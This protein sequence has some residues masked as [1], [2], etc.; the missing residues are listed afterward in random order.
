MSQDTSSRIQVT[1]KWSKQTYQLTLDKSESAIA[2]KQNIQALT[3]VPIH[4]QKLLASKKGA[5]K[6]PLKDDYPMDSIQPQTQTTTS[7]STIPL[8]IVTLI[9]SADVLSEGPKIKTR[10]EEDLTM[11]EIRAAE[12]VTIQQAM[13][14]SHGMIPAFQKLPHERNDNKAE[15]YQYNHMV[16]G[17]P[18]RQIE[19]L[20]VKQSVDNSTATLLGESN[21]IVMT[22]GMELRRAYI[23]DMAV[24]KDGTLVSALD[25]GHIQLWKYGEQQHD[26]IH[27]QGIHGSVIGHQ[28]NDNGVES[29]ASWHDQPTNLAF[30]TAG[31]GLIQ[32]WDVEAEPIIGF[33]ASP[34]PGATTPT[35]LVKLPLTGVVGLA[36]RFRI[37]RMHNPNQFRL[38]PQNPSERARRQQAELEERTLQET[39]NKISKSIQVWYSIDGRSG[40]GENN[41][42][43]AA[44]AS[45]IEM[46]SQILNGNGD[47]D[48]G[49]RIT[50]LETIPLGANETAACLL[51]AGDTN[52]GIKVWK[53]Q[54]NAE[55]DDLDFIQTSYSRLSFDRNESGTQACSI[56][57]IKSLKNGLVVVSTDITADHSIEEEVVMGDAN[58]TNH[59]SVPSGRAVHILDPTKEIPSLVATL[60]GHKDAVQTICELPNGDLLTG[61]GKLDAKLQLWSHSQFDHNV[62]NSNGD[63][64]TKPP[65]A[66]SPAKTLPSEI[67]YVLCLQ[68]LTDLKEDSPHFAVAAARYNV[69][70][71]LL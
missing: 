7:S 68:L 17:L 63:E 71:I 14:H 16:L 57:C 11:E 15:L 51:L 40:G 6:G 65:L 43:N 60:D 29:V 41:D 2:F 24:L 3:G 26:I 25:D 42:E 59:I 58:N 9:G 28:P 35:S 66:T 36:A 22:M 47:D 31:R 34:I 13:K 10:F 61:G 1:L 56:K 50:C 55:H 33:H 39:L 18:Q 64:S 20:L 44:T 45:S 49:G 62:K 53:V 32:L 52:G 5:W 27:G 4:R 37:T 48:S 54:L 46:K 67:G 69:V 19:D 8:L 12:E 21:S 23:N 70:K 30:A 38:P